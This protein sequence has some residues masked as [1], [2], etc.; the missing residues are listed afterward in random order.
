MI[1]RHALL[2]LAA[3]LRQRVCRRSTGTE[4][5]LAQAET[6]VQSAVSA[7][8]ASAAPTNMRAAEDNLASARGALERRNWTAVR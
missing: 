2:L 4:I 3:L 5:A 8:A 7:D 6:A 1:Q